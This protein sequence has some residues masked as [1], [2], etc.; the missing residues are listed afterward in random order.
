MEEKLKELVN[1]F[2]GRS[3][4]K[5]GRVYCIIPSEYSTGFRIHFKVIFPDRELTFIYFDGKFDVWRVDKV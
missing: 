3:I 2:R 1:K 4:S 5:N